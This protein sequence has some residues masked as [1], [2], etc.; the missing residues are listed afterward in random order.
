MVVGFSAL[1][2]ILGKTLTTYVIEPLYASTCSAFCC[3]PSR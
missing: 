2:A 3:R 1:S